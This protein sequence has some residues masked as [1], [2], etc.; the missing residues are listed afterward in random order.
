MSIN[1]S[2][3]WKQRRCSTTERYWKALK[4][5]TRVK[6]TFNILRLVRPWSKWFSVG[7]NRF[8]L[9]FAKLDWQIKKNKHIKGIEYLWIALEI[10]KSSIT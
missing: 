5:K 6:L 3:Q 1:W 10:S 7:K 4:I 9:D 2:E 8:G